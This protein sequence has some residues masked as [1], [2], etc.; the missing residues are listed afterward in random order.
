MN[1]CRITVYSHSKGKDD[2]EL[3]DVYRIIRRRRKR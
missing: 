1:A 3:E 2:E